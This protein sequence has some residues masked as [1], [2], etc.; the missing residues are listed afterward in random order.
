MAIPRYEAGDVLAGRYTVTGTLGTG[1]TSGVFRA[2]DTV[3]NRT[4]AIKVISMEGSENASKSFMT[5]ARAAALLSHPNI[6]NVYDILDLDGEKYIIMEYVCGI[7]LRDYLDYRGHLSPKECVNCAHQ[8]L[9]AL[10][11]AHNRGIVHRD[12]K[13]R[14]LLI[15]TEGRVKVTDFGIA[16]LPDRDSFLMPDR[17]V[18]TVHY[19]SQVGS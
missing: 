10:H 17:T 5:E 3:M 7:T 4:V 1:G 15:T 14:N 12:I 19:I 11:A 6:V 16:R 2:H 9:R 13:P 18:G 8:V